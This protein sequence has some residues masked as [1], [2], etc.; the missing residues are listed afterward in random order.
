MNPWSLA[1]ISGGLI[2]DKYS[3]AEFGLSQ[4]IITGTIIGALFGDVNTGIFLGAMIQLIFLGGLPI[5]GDIPPDG[6]AAG[7]VGTGTYFFLRTVNSPEHS[8]LAAVVLAMTAGLVGGATEI[9]VR[10]IHE[11]LYRCFENR[12][13][14]LM[15][16]HLA[17]LATAFTR[18]SLLCLPFFLI[19]QIIVVPEFFPQL[20]RDLLI[21][22]AVGIGL[23]NSIYFFVKRT[24]ILYFIVG[25]ICGLILLA[26]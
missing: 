8:L 10:R 20:N 21:M 22:V 26:L 24:T 19:A 18:G 25:M 4:P 17:G 14:R 13:G 2:L 3:F 11:Y 23:A 5:G 1:L 9:Y 15:G 16:C 7:I 12:K 6:P